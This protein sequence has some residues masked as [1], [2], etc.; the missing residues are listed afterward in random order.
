MLHPDTLSA[1]TDQK[2][3]EHAGKVCGSKGEFKVI[4]CACCEF[5]H[6]IPLPTAEELETVYAHEY[7]TQEK[8]LY[9]ERYLQ[10]RRW[11]ENVYD[12]RLQLFEKF[13]DQSERKILDI[14]SGPGIFLAKARNR[15]WLTMG[16]EPSKEAA[17]FSQNKLGLDIKNIFYNN[18]SSARIGKFSCVHI[19]EV[20]EHITDPEAFVLQTKENLEKNGL[21]AAIVPNDFN[22][23]Q[24]LISK[25]QKKKPW[26]IAPPHHLNYFNPKSLTILLEKCGFEIIHLENTFPIDLFVLMGLDYV[27]ND[28]IGRNAHGM[29][30]SFENILFESNSEEREI[31][32]TLYK[33]FTEIGIGREIFIVGRKK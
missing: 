1:W 11:W 16:L 13:L 31:I 10:D 32:K 3:R 20:L 9:I 23:I 12:L 2:G 21:L 30:M 8:P 7:Y 33:K 4:E 5:K 26:W 28:D 19:G 22:P 18:E 25:E 15:G 17:N 27:E 6:V 24:I 14:G 29:R